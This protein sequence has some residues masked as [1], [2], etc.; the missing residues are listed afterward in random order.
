MKRI[1]LV[2]ALALML[3]IGVWDQA[4]ATQTNFGDE[5]DDHPWGGLSPGD[6]PQYRHELS[7]TSILVTTGIFPVDVILS[8]HI[9]L[10]E[11]LNIFI[12]DAKVEDLESE[13]SNSRDKTTVKR[14][15]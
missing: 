2:L 7:S 6:Q 10:N 5:G 3:L 4:M 9:F 11:I 1:I 15:R 12:E 14:L 8:D 13:I